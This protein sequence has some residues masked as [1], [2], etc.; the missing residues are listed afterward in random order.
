MISNDLL[1]NIFENSNLPEG[2]N[3]RKLK[4]DIFAKS[5]FTV[6]RIQSDK[7]FILKEINIPEMAETEFRSIKILDSYNIPVPKP[8]LLVKSNSNYY[9]LMEYIEKTSISETGFLETMKSL[10][11][12]TKDKWGL[13]FS[14]Y[15]GTLAQTNIETN[16]WEEFFWKCRLEP[17]VDLAIQNKK[18]QIS[19]KTQLK[20]ILEL[21]KEWNLGSAKPRLIHGDLWSGNVIGTHSKMVLIDPSISFAHP[22]Q[23]LGMASLFGG[24]PS[25]LF[26]E[27]LKSVG[28]DSYGFGDRVSFWQIYPLLVHVNIFGKSYQRDLENAMNKYLK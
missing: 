14:N 12:V 22:E 19:H 21:T 2:F 13:S 16:S 1:R 5:L 20:K 27:V 23:D 24:F 11:S 15:I 9:I 25:H 4:I 17:Q 10:Y 18:L 28:I 7:D 6:Y 26:S 8:F 3:L